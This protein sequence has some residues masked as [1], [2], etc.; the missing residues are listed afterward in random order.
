MPGKE[1][2]QA[3]KKKPDTLE[4]QLIE[5]NERFKRNPD[6]IFRKIVDELVLIP[7]HK[8]V[9]DMDSIFSLNEVGAF[10]WEQLANPINMEDLKKSIFKEFDVESEALSEDVQSFI[11]D[12]SEFGAVVRSE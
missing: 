4:D 5:A 9:A 7:I 6:Y 11:S 12:L 10:I 3:F 2:Y 8:D 1:I